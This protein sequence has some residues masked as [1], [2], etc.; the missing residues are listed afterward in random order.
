[1]ARD[2]FLYE[3]SWF[4]DQTGNWGF[5]F[6]FTV[7]PLPFQTMSGFPY[8][9]SENYPNDTAHQAYLAQWNTR[10]YAEPP[11]QNTTISQNSFAIPALSTFA[12]GA[13]MIYVNYKVGAFR[14]SLP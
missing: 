9:P 8:P 11:T 14:H 4:K 2:Y 6:G 1:M 3:A 7:D 10:V 13:V 12:V 5:G